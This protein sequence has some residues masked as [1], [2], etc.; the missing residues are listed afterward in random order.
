MDKHRAIVKLSVDS[1]QTRPFTLV[2]VNPYTPALN[3]PE[4]V[5]VIKNISAIKRG[6]QKEFVEKEIFFKLGQ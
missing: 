2:P 3:S 5:A 1:M 4:T 6:R